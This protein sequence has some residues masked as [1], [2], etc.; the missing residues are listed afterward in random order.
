MVRSCNICH[1]AASSRTNVN[2]HVL[3]QGMVLSPSRLPYTMDLPAYSCRPPIMDIPF[4]QGSVC[5]L[6]AV[7]ESG[8]CHSF[9]NTS[10]VNHPSQ[11]ENTIDCILALFLHI[12]R[13]RQDHPSPMAL[14][15]QS[16]QSYVI[17]RLFLAH[18]FQ[19]CRHFCLC[20]Y[21]TK[22]TQFYILPSRAN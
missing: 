22:Y 1:F 8:S 10:F 13:C 20:H 4:S 21:L 18:H 9:L 7:S 5:Y 12:L 11:N 17:I 15:A 3:G 19:R 14:S 16:D 6:L 2:N